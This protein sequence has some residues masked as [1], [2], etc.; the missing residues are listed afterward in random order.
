MAYLVPFGITLLTL[1]VEL[2]AP[3]C[4][5]F[6]PRF[7]ET[8]CFFSGTTSKTLW[9]YLPI[10]LSLLF[11]TYKFVLTIK[12]VREVDKESSRFTK[13]SDSNSSGV[14]TTCCGRITHQKDRFYMFLKHFIGIG[15]LWSFEVISGLLDDHVAEEVWYVTDVLNMLQGLYIFIIFV[16]KRSVLEAILKWMG[17]GKKKRSK[18][19]PLLPIS[20]KNQHLRPSLQDTTN[21][22][23]ENKSNNFT[24]QTAIQ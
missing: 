7:T 6:K 12:A 3:R 19:F 9:F 2:W 4:S 8:G 10:G 13:R 24:E 21:S 17:C 11:N 5:V 23:S 1:F 15:I 16:C 14:E 20:G 22:M 18:T